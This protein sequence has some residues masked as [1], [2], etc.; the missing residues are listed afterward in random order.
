[1]RERELLGLSWQDLDRERDSLQVWMNLQESDRRFIFAE[2][3][4]A[5]S[6]RSNG[7]TQ[8]AVA[9]LRQHKAKREDRIDLGD[10][11]DTKVDLAFPNRLGGIMI[12]D[13]LAKRSF[14]Q[15]LGKIGLPP[16]VPFHDLRHS[17]ATLLLSR[18]V[19]PKHSH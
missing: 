8:K 9:A 18:G 5:N 16:N 19:H 3:N 14:K 12:P 10:A 4:A 13:N 2:T 17:T 6:L 15:A 1:M 11:W 7:L